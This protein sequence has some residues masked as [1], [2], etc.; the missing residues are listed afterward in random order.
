MSSAA[1]TKALTAT[2]YLLPNG[3]SAPGL[4]RV[5]PV[6]ATSRLRSVLTDDRVG[7]NADAVF[8]AHNA[9]TAIFKDAGD[10]APT[11]K[12]IADWHEAAWNVIAIAGYLRQAPF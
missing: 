5:G 3:E 4:T 9:P 1:F 6:V 11:D 8:S 12:Q 10:N 7:L 2:G